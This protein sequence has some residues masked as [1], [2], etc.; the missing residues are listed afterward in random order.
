M[1]RIAVFRRRVLDTVRQAA[2]DIQAVRRYRHLDRRIQ[3]KVNHSG[4]H[5]RDRTGR[6]SLPNWL[7]HSLP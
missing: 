6:G 3:A 7:V 4:V 2:N 1:E 5:C